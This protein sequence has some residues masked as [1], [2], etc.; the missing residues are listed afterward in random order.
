[1]SDTIHGYR[2]TPVDLLVDAAR[3]TE[4]KQEAM[5]LR[6]ITLDDR[7][8]RDLELMLGGA[9]APLDG[10]MGREDYESVLERQCLAN[11]TF[12]PRPFTLD[13]DA[14]TAGSLQGEE[15]V[16][17]RDDEGAMLA[18]LTLGDVWQPDWR[19]ERA[20]L[21]PDGAT[22]GEETIADE[23]SAPYALGGRIEGISRPLHHDYP[24]LRVT[25]MGLKAELKA[26]GWTRMI[27]VDPSAEL[28]PS[29][30]RTIAAIARELGALVLLHPVMDAI[31][32]TELEL[33]RR[34][35]Q[36]RSLLAHYPSGGARL[37]LLPLNPSGSGARE[38]LWR[39]FVHHRC[40]ATHYFLDP[41]DMELGKGV[42]GS[43]PMRDLASACKDHLGLEL[44]SVLDLRIPAEDLA[45]ANPMPI[46]APGS[47]GAWSEGLMAGE[48]DAKCDTSGVTCFFTGLSGA[49]KSTVA[50]ALAAQLSKLGRTVTLLDGDLVRRHLS[51]ELTFSKEHRDLN[52]RRIGYVASEI[53]RHGGIAICAPIAPYRVTRAAVRSLIE[54]EGGFLEIH[55]STP[56]EVCEQR[57]PKGLYAK[58]HAG[59]IKDF[60]GIN[61][62]YEA[63]EHPEIAIDTSVMGVEAAVALILTEL[64]RRGAI[65]DSSPAMDEGILDR[66]QTRR[67]MIARQG[68]SADV[69]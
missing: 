40:G 45:G 56:L 35:K 11:G 41:R 46:G 26:G 15:R 57:D 51:S 10:Y 7:Q 60:T 62:P 24:D 32:S 49:G 63:P 39:A 29:G 1:M 65:L 68:G 23:G 2:S 22:H 20:I 37:A 30:H 50:R 31:R 33:H 34:V 8:T 69:G 67:R 47:D 17:L 6:S 5:R 19:R 14:D 38:W 44:L 66:T 48:G 28:P 13:L 58:A 36:Y 4:I 64:R 27:V 52:I 21:H 9:C 16:V 18:I 55:V 59:L 42:A 54:A 61:D 3:A 12:F 25:P 43:V 53:T